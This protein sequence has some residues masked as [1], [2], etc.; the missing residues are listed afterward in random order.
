MGWN[1]PGSVVSVAVMAG[2][3]GAGALASAPATASAPAAAAPADPL[4]VERPRFESIDGSPLGVTGVGSFRG[5]IE[6]VRSG[7]GLAVVN[8]VA[9]DDYLRGIA[10][11]PAGWPLEA[12]KAQAIAARTYA[13]YETG[14]RTNTAHRAAGA[15]ICATQA[16]QVY[17]GLAKER[18]PSG[19]AWGAAVDQTKGQ[20]LVHRGAPIAAKYSSSNGGR[21][22][23]GGRPYLRATD[24][25]DDRQ[26]PLHRWQPSYPLAEVVRAAGFA[27][28]TTD[29]HRAGDEMVAVSP[30]PDG[31][32]VEQRLPAIDFRIRLN[33]KLPTPPGLP[34]PLPSIRFD[35]AT[36]DGIVHFQGRGWGHGIGMSQYGALGKALRGQRAND[37]LAAYYAG[38]RPVALPDDRLPQRLKVA[39]ALDRGMV[40]VA[41][42][43]GPFRILD[44][45]GQVVAHHATGTWSARPAGK[46]RVKLV[47]P[48]D[49]RAAPTASLVAIETAAPPAAGSPMTVI[50]QLTLDGP[51]AVTRLTLARP[52]GGIVEVEPPTVRG[53]GPI[54]VILPAADTATPGVYRI[55]VERDAGGGR[56]AVTGLPIDLS[57]GAVA[58]LPPVVAAVAPG[59]GHG[60]DDAPPRP[61]LEL[62]ALFLL[63]A[64]ALAAAGAVRTWVGRPP[65]LQLH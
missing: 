33:E 17:V 1:R 40:A 48:P 39:V 49:Q 38:L 22:V 31:N 42:E 65:D 8:D 51:A 34:L 11:M 37:I 55:D 64:V 24:D 3:L 5:A 21:T 36:A 14:L 44:A 6:V 12:Q 50:A 30:D 16:C 25:P 13:L 27:P 29:V 15:D 10:E 35:A 20:V 46:G 59:A 7:A 62:L 41:G 2:A 56:G 57:P 63:G 26:S 9:F 45:A 52:D 19:S 4:V 28:S 18:S 54:A 58:A 47:P 60:H 32:P 61:L 43:P 53:A 23:A